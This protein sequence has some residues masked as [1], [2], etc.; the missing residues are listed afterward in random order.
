MLHGQ[1]NNAPIEQHWPTVRLYAE[2]RG[3]GQAAWLE[4]VQQAPLANLQDKV[5]NLSNAA[6]VAHG[7]YGAQL[8]Y[9]IRLIAV[10]ERKCRSAKRSAGIRSKFIDAVDV[11]LDSLIA[12]MG[13]AG[14]LKE[15]K[16]MLKAQAH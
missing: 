12:A 11:L 10:L 2:V 3:Q 1:K 4:Y 16:D 15:L 5:D 9:K 8:K 6:L 13:T 7:L 14:A